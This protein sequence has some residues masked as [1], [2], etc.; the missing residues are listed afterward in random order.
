ME[1]SSLVNINLPDTL[2]YIGEQA[3]S[4]CTKLREI[5]IPD[6][7][8][9]INE[10]A[11]EDCPS[12]ERI[13]IKN[14]RLLED[15][16]L[17]D[18]VQI[19]TD[20]DKKDIPDPARRPARKYVF[21]YAINAT[22]GQ[23]VKDL[24]G[25]KKQAPDSFIS[26]TLG[27]GSEVYVRSVRLWNGI[28]ILRT[29]G[30]DEDAM[31]VADLLEELKGQDNDTQVVLELGW[32][33][34]N[35]S[36]KKNGSVIWYDDD[37]ECCWINYENDI[38][39]FKVEDLSELVRYYAKKC[40]D[41]KVVCLA[42]D[43]IYYPVAD[44]YEDD[45]D[46][47]VIVRKMNDGK[48]VTISKFANSLGDDEVVLFFE[49]KSETAVYKAVGAVKS[50]VFFEDVVDGEDVIAFHLGETL[51]DERIEDDSDDEFW[52]D[53]DT[54]VTLDDLCDK[55]EE[56]ESVVE[57]EPDVEFE[58]ESEVIKNEK[59]KS[60]V[61]QSIQEIKEKEK[62]AEAG[63]EG[64]SDGESSKNGDYILKLVSYEGSVIK[65]M[66]VLSSIEGIDEEAAF[67]KLQKL[68]SVVLEGLSVK[69]AMEIG[70]MLEEA[71]A[72]VD[73]ARASD[74]VPEDLVPE[75]SP[76]PSPKPGSKHAPKPTPASLV[77]EKPKQAPMEYVDLGLSVKWA[78]CNLGASVPEEFGD[79]FAWGETEKH[80]FTDNR[81]YK[82]SGKGGLTKY[83]TKEA[84]GNVVDNIKQL[85][86]SDDAA[87]QILGDGWR[88]PTI[89]EMNEL[90]LN[91]KVSKTVI[92]GVPGEKYTSK[93]KGYT[94]KWIFL[95]GAG[96][97]VGDS[98]HWKGT[99]RYWTSTLY[100]RRPDCAMMLMDEVGEEKT[101]RSY[102]SL[103]I[104]AV[105]K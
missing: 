58:P 76:K 67:C 102:S 69:K 43:G 82:F 70:T 97:W 50:G 81:K 40:P 98:H 101:Y 8:K 5:K 60:S 88:M 36:P 80:D 37:D 96:E 13:Y 56:K 65:M 24:N 1:C 23:L 47:F 63:D 72:K 85:E 48:G 9:V 7:V 21:Q 45:G 100:T 18:D 92:N 49:N 62:A 55:E 61:L 3:F 86:L 25:I 103:S 32:R 29:C 54:V 2:T 94:D 11:F 99:C 64:A 104:R 6:S 83:N 12:L 46:G 52:N 22:V 68:P 17:E 20:S 26:T 57:K 15:T 59:L 42:D 71:G 77:P 66:T 44:V 105:T 95:P 30:D 87:H 79:Y 35:L 78:K 51:Y 38:R 53:D 31:S 14:P 39:L 4:G 27:N 19:I 28:I 16:G 74:P 41:R 90:R 84:Y 89:K 73:L 75:S 34:V 33:L 10:D 93:V 91:C